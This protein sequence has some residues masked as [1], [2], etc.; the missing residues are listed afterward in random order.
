MSAAAAVLAPPAP[1]RVLAPAPVA[2]AA[3]QRRLAGLDGVPAWAR[4]AGSGITLTVLVWR[5][6]TGPFVVY[7]IMVLVASLPGA[8]VLVVSWSRRIRP[9]QR[10]NRPLAE[11]PARA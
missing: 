9:P 3:P 7:G 8:A 5:L 4:L 11:E 2:A 1:E 10:R 6:G